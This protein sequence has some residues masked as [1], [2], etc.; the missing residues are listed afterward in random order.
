M[1]KKVTAPLIDFP[2]R[3]VTP[4]HLAKLQDNL[5]RARAG[6][7]AKVLAKRI[8]AARALLADNPGE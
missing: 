4:E 2:R 7:A 1:S 5:A 8:A 6:R 3:A